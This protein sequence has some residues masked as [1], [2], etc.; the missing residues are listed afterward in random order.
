MAEYI[1]I[2]LI[3]NKTPE[4]ITSELEDRESHRLSL[5]ECFADPTGSKS[6]ALTTVSTTHCCGRFE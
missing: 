4:Q 6:S 2:M 1:T 5:R 3:N